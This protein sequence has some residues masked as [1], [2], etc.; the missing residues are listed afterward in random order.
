[1]VQDIDIVTRED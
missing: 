1:M